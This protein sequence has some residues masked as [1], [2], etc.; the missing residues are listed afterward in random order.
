MSAVPVP[1]SP[2]LRPADLGDRTECVALWVQ[3]CAE[4]DGQAYPGVAER[5]APKF[6]DRVA[7]IV[8]EHP[9][10]E[11]VGFALAT[12]PGSA[13]QSDPPAAAVL[14]L[15]AVDPHVQMAGLGRKLLAKITG[16]LAD[17]GFE[18]AVL[19]VLSENTAAIR[20]YE[21]A[22]WMPVGPPIEHSLLKRP[23][24]TYVVELA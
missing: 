17:L 7:W 20:L 10:G 5:A 12:K 23:S 22:G 21:S 1:D 13:D 15:L 3:A 9:A 2:S 19:H 6:D 16:E 4:R 14:G 8:A 18:Q 24:Q 11:I